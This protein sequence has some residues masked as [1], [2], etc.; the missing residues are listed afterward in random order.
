MRIYN[1]NNSKIAKAFQIHIC[2]S[3]AKL[4]FEHNWE[5]VSCQWCFCFKRWFA[6]VWKKN[7]IPAF[8]N[9]R[10]KT[11]MLFCASCKWTRL[12]SAEAIRT[13]CTARNGLYEFNRCMDKQWQKEII[14]RI[15]SDVI[16]GF[17]W[18]VQS[19]WW[20]RSPGNNQNNAANV[21]SDGN[22]NANGNNVKNDN[23]GVRPALPSYAGNIY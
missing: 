7:R 17:G 2:K 3:F 9:D 11:L 22:V 14:I 20:L 1:D 5:I 15:I 16:R 21:N 6:I 12:Y 18:K 13:N 23:N 19:W 8:C 10:C 4:I